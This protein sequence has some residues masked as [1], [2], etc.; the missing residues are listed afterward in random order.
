MTVVEVGHVH[1]F[2]AFDFG[3]P[4]FLEGV[5]DGGLNPRI[6]GGGAENWHKFCRRFLGSQEVGR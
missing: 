5:V 3:R 4:L 2:A 1:E 6:F